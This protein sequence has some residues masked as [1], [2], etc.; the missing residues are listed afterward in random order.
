MSWLYSQAL[1]AEYSVD[2]CSD[3]AQSAQSNGN[4]TQLGA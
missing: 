1:V 4:H 3:G 2:I